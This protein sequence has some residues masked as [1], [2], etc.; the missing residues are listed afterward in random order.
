[1]DGVEATGPA[2]RPMRILVVANLYPSTGHPAFGTFVEARVE[3]LRRAGHEVAVAAITDDR[4]HERIGPKYLMLGLRSLRAG[5][6][7]RL[8]RRPYDVVEAHIAFPTGLAAWPAA[9]LGRGQLVLFCHGSDVTT[10]PW[11]SHAR[12]TLARW[13]FR[14][15][16]AVIANSAHTA[17]IA[18]HR[19]GP[20]KRKPRVISPGIVVPA[21]EH[22]PSGSQRPSN[23]IVFVGR[24]VAGK[25]AEV[26]IA[27]VAR[28][29]AMGLPGRLT[30]VGDGPLREALER[31]AAGLDDRVRFTGALAPAD[32][33]TL[34]RTATVVA[35][36]ST[37]DEGLSLVALEAMAQGALVV[38]T[39]AGG[40]AETMR[41]GEN[42]IVVPRDD[43]A[44]L[45]NA[46]TRLM[47]IGN[48]PAGERLRW[49]GHITASRHDIDRAV[50]ESI[51]SHEDLFR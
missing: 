42:G 45:A 40:L 47:E 38:A 27:A 50:A 28:S 9:R 41:D 21:W 23:E 3:A 1:M 29:V 33:A 35:V 6:G 2:H 44:A 25:G 16:D 46:I 20:L 34:F 49:N 36:P 12:A 13:L 31:Q 7:A 4:P 48:T 24:L 8:R 26:V 15:A 43:N 32:V 30:V 14:R 18:E 10:L 39:S 11:K 19:L 5:V 17:H 37:T 51:R 22:V